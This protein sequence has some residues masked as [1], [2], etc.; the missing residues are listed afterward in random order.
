MPLAAGNAINAQSMPKENFVVIVSNRMAG[1][2]IIFNTV[3]FMNIWALI[4]VFKDIYSFCYPFCSTNQNIKINFRIVLE[5][6]FLKI[7]FI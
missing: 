5:R 3:N 4:V 1:V 2:V 7:V 6:L